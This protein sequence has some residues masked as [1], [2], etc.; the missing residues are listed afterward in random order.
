ES[1][2]EAYKHVSKEV[3]SLKYLKK[4]LLFKERNYGKEDERTKE[5]RAEV[6]EKR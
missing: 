1:L 5:T 3:L 6:E 4:V 2:A